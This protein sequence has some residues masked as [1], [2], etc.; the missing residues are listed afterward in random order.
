MRLS[1]N[2]NPLFKAFGLEK[3]IDIFAGAGF[4][5]MDLSAY[6]SEFFTDVHDKEY[7]VGIKKYAQS[8]GL[9]FN[10]A[11][12]PHGS[13]FADEEKTAKRFEEI[14]TSMKNASYLGVEHIIVHPCQHLIYDDEGNPERLFEYNMDFYKRLIPYCEEYGIKVAVENMWQYPGVI[15]HSTCSK[16]DEFIRYV[17]E[18]NNDCF[19]ACLDIGH[20]VLVREK[21]DDFIRALGN[22]RLK[23]LHVHDVDGL[24]D[25]HAMPYL[26]IA[27][28]DKITKALAEIDYQGDFTYEVRPFAARSEEC[29]YKR[30]LPEE[31]F[32]DFYKLMSAT[33]RY[34]IGKI[35]EMKKE[36]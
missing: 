4:D 19:V 17:D 34:L 28:W 23:C 18:L 27:D 15:S 16:P 13:S 5:A 3:T 9:V 8:K 22:E 21:P 11:H 1:A 7:Y 29:G 33:G 12:A 24:Y 31:L 20:C 10:Q 35:E 6:E 32:A 14:V 36:L 30:K 2:T 25:I 26:G